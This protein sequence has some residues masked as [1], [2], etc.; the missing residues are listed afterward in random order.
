MKKPKHILVIRLSSMGDVAMTVPVLREFLNSNLDYKV[1]VLTKFQYFCFF[2][3]IERIN[4]IEFDKTKRHR[5]VFGLV[6]LYRDLKKTEIDFIVDLHNVLRTNFL[7]VL[8][9]IPFYQIDKGRDEKQKLISGKL[10]KALKS[11]HQRYRDVFEK[12]GVL[13]TPL[14]TC[15][16]NKAD[17]SKLKISLKK[18]TKIIGI[19]PF[20]AHNGKAYPIAQMEAVIKDMNKDFSIVLFGGGK[21]E[22]S[23]L[24]EL[25]RKHTNV[26]NIANKYSLD[27]EMDVISNLNIMLSMDSANGHIAALLGVKVLTIWGLT[28]PFAGF[29]PYG[30][31]EE[32]NIVVNRV[33]FPKIPTSIY[34]N[35]IPK[36]YEKAISSITSEEIIFALRRLA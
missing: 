20:A 5:G 21:I 31:K 16:Q 24:D 33:H 29:S 1:S 30:Q 6:R 35:K 15:K 3:E 34:G 8:F 22:E 12:L 2:R 26:I 19:A 10:F 13:I 11:T 36:G 14:K 32:N 28:H 17:I 18:D 25:A 7:K 4:L 9:T 23:I 27:Q